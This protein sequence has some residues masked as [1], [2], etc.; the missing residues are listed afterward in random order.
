MKVAGIVYNVH[1]LKNSSI[2]H[3]RYPIVYDGFHSSCKKSMQI[4]PSGSTLGWNTFVRKIICQIKWKFKK[5]I[6]HMY[7]A[8]QKLHSKIESTNTEIQDII[9][10]AT[11]P[12]EDGMGS[13]Q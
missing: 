12:L 7:N 4:L 2:Q 9:E 1:K 10:T 11:E 3:L 6:I 13:R 8:D 5:F